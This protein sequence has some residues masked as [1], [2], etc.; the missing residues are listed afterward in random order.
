MQYSSCSVPAEAE[1][2]VILIV[3]KFPLITSS[4]VFDCVSVTLTKQFPDIP[5]TA[6][7]KTTVNPFVPAEKE[8]TLID[9]SVLVAST[10]RVRDPSRPRGYRSSRLS[11]ASCNVR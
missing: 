2:K 6:E 4:V 1:G 5:V 7:S 3:E 9:F 11:Q 8:A 10:N